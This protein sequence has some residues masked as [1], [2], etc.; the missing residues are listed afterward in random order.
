MPEPSFPP[1]TSVLRRHVARVRELEASAQVQELVDH[2]E[3]PQVLQTELL[4]AARAVE[5]CV[6]PEALAPLPGTRDDEEPAEE[7][8][9][10]HFG[11]R[12]VITVE[13]DEPLVFT[14]L[15]GAVD[16]LQPPGTPPA[17]GEGLD[18]LG[19]LHDCEHGGVLGAVRGDVCDTPYALLLRALCGLSEMLPEIQ[20]R[21]LDAELLKGSFGD[22]PVLDL[23]L[24]L[25]DGDDEEDADPE[26]ARLMAQLTRDLADV[27]RASLLGQTEF[28]ADLGRIVCLRM[29]PDRFDG[30]LRMDWCV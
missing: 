14:C 22:Q 20:L 5:R 24:V 2:L 15:T 29:D 8:V 11:P 23:H 6:D 1:L 25:W 13:A 18:Y 9:L 21:R 10:E 12:R 4:E 27:V 17:P 7:L 28:G 16:P 26:S 19:L 30:R 3:H